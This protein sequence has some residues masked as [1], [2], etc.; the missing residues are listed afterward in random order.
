MLLL[1]MVIAGETW[2]L[3]DLRPSECPVAV[4]AA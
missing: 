3:L 1:L 4:D 2:L